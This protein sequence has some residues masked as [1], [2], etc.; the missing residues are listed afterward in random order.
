[1]NL[2][3]DEERARLA[4]A[5]LAAADTPIPTQIVSSDEY[6][7]IPQTAKQREVEA[8]LTLLAD[9][10]ARRQ[11]ITR[12]Q[13]FRTAAGMAAAYLA[14][15]DVYGPL[16]QVS[17]A[18]AAT[19]ELADERANQLGGQFIFD[20]HTHFL[21]DD[22]RLEGFVRMREA[23]GKAGWNPALVDKPQ[24][25]EDLK[26]ENY[27]KEVFL[28][29]DTKIAIISSAPSEIAGDWFLTNQM[30]AQARAR[31]NEMTG[32]RRM[33]S[34]AIFTPGQ[35]GWVEAVERAIEEDKPDS[36]KG[37]TIGDNTHKELSKHPWRMDDERRLYPF[38]ERLWKVGIRNVCVHKGLFPPS[39][40]KQYPH[41]REYC[42]V[43]DVGRAAK[44]WPMLNFIIYHSAYRFP[45]GGTPEEALA[46]FEQ[47][48]RVDWVSDLAEIPEK[49]G[50]RNV[51]GDLGQVFAMTTVAQPRLCA[52]IMGIL[53]KG[54]GADRIVWGSDAVWTGAPQW[55]IEGLRRLE[56]PEEM[57]RKHGFAP[58]GAAT[59]PVK[60]AI[61][62]ETSARLYGI[63][64][65]AYAGL[66]DRLTMAKAQYR[67]RGASPSN[68]RYG[69]IA[70]A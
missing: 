23:V 48:G 22:T 25:I 60:S 21:R 3:T 55:Q 10:L 40:E 5:E 43:R 42:D 38:Y 31:V 65:A 44:D 20:G 70:P 52:A 64:P 41:L 27:F 1:V 53:V 68:L 59:G 29:S 35:L 24:G 7:P 6:L 32:S 51:Y 26:F 28:D 19:P 33:L 63:K 11:G 17:R 15:N 4:P 66:S 34:H 30:T 13:F 37:Y 61:F 57:Q 62:G 9:E 69:Y 2:L 50:V 58:L 47:T 36:F 8:R 12:R 49:F 56:I 45:G 67:R 46:Q 18:E 54:L 14:M 16:F 39:V